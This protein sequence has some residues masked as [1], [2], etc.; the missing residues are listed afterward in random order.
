LAV[1]PEHPKPPAALSADTVELADTG[2]EGQPLGAAH[3]AVEFEAPPLIPAMRAQ[4]DQVARPEMRHDPS[5][6][7]SY[8]G[9]ASRLIDAMEAGATRS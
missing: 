8:R 9:A 2:Q 7:T 6:V 3:G 4:L 1:G 5:N